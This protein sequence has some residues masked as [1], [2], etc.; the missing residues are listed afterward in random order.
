MTYIPQEAKE[1]IAQLMENVE[2]LESEKSTL[3]SELNT[4]KDKFNTTK[5]ALIAIIALLVIALVF[6]YMYGSSSNSS[7]KVK[8]EAYIKKIE[9]QNNNYKV[10]IKKLRAKISANE[11]NTPDLLYK[12]QIGAFKSFELPSFIKDKKDISE[13]TKDGLKKYSLGAFTKYKDALKFKK[14]VKHL[15]FRDAFLVVTYK[16]EEINVKEG[17]K[18]ENR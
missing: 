4:R 17:I 18:L 8:T 7:S 15:G 14:E 5:Y 11:G 13:S 2:K 6:V 12:V 9:K 3:K 16:G 10:T 1:E